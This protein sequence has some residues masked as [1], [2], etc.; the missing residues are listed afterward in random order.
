MFSLDE[1]CSKSLPYFRQLIH[2][3][4]HSLITHST[5]RKGCVRL[6]IFL[7]IL[8]V[9]PFIFDQKKNLI[10]SNHVSSAVQLQQFM[11]PAHIIYGMWVIHLITALPCCPSAPHRTYTEYIV[12][13]TC[14]VVSAMRMI[15]YSEN[16]RVPPK[17][18]DKCYIISKKNVGGI[19][20]AFRWEY[21]EIIS[22]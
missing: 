7:L 14:F 8:S 5:P 13:A 22:I 3:C 4:V 20:C 17:R 9:S 18:R 11:G 6:T 21:F 12:Y 19:Y 2:N 15:L 10:P 1:K 16:Y